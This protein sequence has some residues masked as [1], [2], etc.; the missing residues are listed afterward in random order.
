MSVNKNAKGEKK[1]T[2]VR[3]CTLGS[4]KGGEDGDLDL[5]EKVREAGHRVSE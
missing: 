5:R 4:S 2:V 3:A 1:G